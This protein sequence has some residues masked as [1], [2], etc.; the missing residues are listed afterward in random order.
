M[1][2]CLVL[3]TISHFYLKTLMQMFHVNVRTLS[4]DSKLL[5]CTHQ[6]RQLHTVLVCWDIL[7][8]YCF[9]I[10]MLTFLWAH[11]AKSY[12]FII[13]FSY[14]SCHTG[15]RTQTAVWGMRQNEKFNV[16]F[17]GGSI[18]SLVKDDQSGGIMLV[19]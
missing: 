2:L 3:G 12:N 11:M 18:P 16:R 19:F 7:H 10:S 14:N 4:I 1:P 9:D 5:L 17:G 13:F 8:I 15:Q 6:N